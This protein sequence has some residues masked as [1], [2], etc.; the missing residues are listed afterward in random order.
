[1]KVRAKAKAIVRARARVETRVGDVLLCEIGANDGDG[2]REHEQARDHGDGRDDLAGRRRGHEVAVAHGGGR[3][4]HPPEAARYGT[5]RCLFSV[6]VPV[7]VVSEEHALGSGLGFGIGLGVGL[8]LGS[9][10]VDVD[11]FY[12]RYE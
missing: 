4:H 12:S 9:G 5:E 10:S 1:M 8:G 2:Q 7:H 6:R 3:D 11:W